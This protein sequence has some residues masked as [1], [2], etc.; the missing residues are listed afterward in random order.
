MDTDQ[1]LLGQRGD[2]VGAGE[3]ELPLICDWPNR[4]RQKVDH[5]HGKPSKTCFSVLQYDPQAQSTAGSLLEG[6]PPAL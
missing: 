3:I 6:L 1:P 5:E 4:P 2:E